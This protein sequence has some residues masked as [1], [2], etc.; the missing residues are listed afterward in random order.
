M[1]TRGR[2][3]ATIPIRDAMDQQRLH[4]LKDSMAKPL[5]AGKQNTSPQQEYR[6]HEGT[7]PCCW[8]AVVVF[9]VCN[10]EYAGT[11][12]TFAYVGPH[13]QR[14]PYK[15]RWRLSARINTQILQS[16]P[17]LRVMII[18]KGLENQPKCQNAPAA[19]WQHQRPNIT[20]AVSYLCNDNTKRIQQ[21]P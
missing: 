15:S 17:S 2:S 13:T 1:G 10:T 12:H 3:N 8:G 20:G 7:H 16:W 5:L 4:P 19:I 9:N 14:R 11:T 21:Q 18:L 6:P